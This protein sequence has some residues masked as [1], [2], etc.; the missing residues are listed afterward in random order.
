MSTRIHRRWVR[1]VN[2]HSTL[3]QMIT[4]IHKQSKR[5]G[6]CVCVCSR[7]HTH[8][9]CACVCYF[10]WSET[11]VLLI[12][13]HVCILRFR[14]LQADIK[15]Y[16]SIRPFH[17]CS[18]AAINSIWFH[19]LLYPFDSWRKSNANAFGRSVVNCDISNVIS[20][21]RC[22]R[23][24]WQARTHNHHRPTTTWF[25]VIKLIATF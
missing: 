23:T 1:C 20:S 6:R 14:H 19:V 16:G 3:M 24:G 13:D 17:M 5:L 25:H 15:S 11:R 2:R 12:V 10:G 22:E 18:N 8:W 7:F 4:K 21:E 9:S